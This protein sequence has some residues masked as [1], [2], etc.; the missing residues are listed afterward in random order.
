MHV[1]TP[2]TCPQRQT[3][4]GLSLP[5]GLSGSRAKQTFAAEDGDLGKRVVAAVALAPD[6]P[7]LAAALAA[8]HVA[9]A[10]VGAVW[11]AVAGQ[12]GVL[13]RGPVVILLREPEAEPGCQCRR[14]PAPGRVLSDVRVPARPAGLTAAVHPWP[15]GRWHLGPRTGWGRG[16]SLTSQ[17][18]L[19]VGQLLFQRG[20]ET[21]W[22]SV[23]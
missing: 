21:Q 6:D 16:F 17:Q 12:A 20:S 1:C 2:P 5:H 11:E 4:S 18:V 19:T 13:P 8:V 22:R 23:H 9:D 3:H 15:P 10:A 14:S 7:G